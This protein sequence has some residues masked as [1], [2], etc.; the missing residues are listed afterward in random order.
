MKKY[1]NR[2]AIGQSLLSV[3]VLAIFILLAIGSIGEIFGLRI[4]ETEV[5]R[6]GNGDYQE[7]MFTVD[8]KRITTGS[9]DKYG[10]WTGDVKIEWTGGR[11]GYT[12]ECNMI[13]GKRWGWSTRTYNISTMNGP[14][15]E[16]DWYV[17]NRRMPKLKSA[18]LSPES[19]SAFELLCDKYPWFLG[20]L[21]MCGFDSIYIETYMDTVVTLV[22]GHERIF[23]ELFNATVF[24]NYYGDALDSLEETPY[25]SIIS[26]NSDLS[27]LKGFEE[28]KNSELRLAIIDRY[29]LNENSTYNIIKTT[30]SNYLLAM[31]DSG[32]VSQDF[33]VFCQTMD[34]CMNSYGT[35]DTEDDF[36]TDSVD[37]RMYRAINN[38]INVEK[39]VSLLSG[40]S[41]K[42]LSIGHKRLD[43]AELTKA[44]RSLVKPETTKSAPNEVGL[45]VLNDMFLRYYVDGDMMRR[46]FK[47]ACYLK[48]NNELGIPLEIEIPSVATGFENNN[49]ATSVNL[50][51]YILDDGGSE[52]TSKGIAWATCYNPTIH[53]QIL[54]SGQGNSDFIV[55]L[56][57]L[58]E[59]TTYHARTFATNSKGTAYGNCISF[60]ANNAVAENTFRQ[61]DMDY[62]IYPNPT[63]ATVTFSFLLE[64]SEN[65]TLNIFDLSGK[66]VAQKKTGRLL[67]GR[68]Q[69]AMDLSGLPDG[70]YTSLLIVG[71]R[72]VSNQLAIAHK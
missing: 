40:L 46:I 31:N 41:L 48:L 2:T 70:L 15:R 57:G 18:G 34:S 58:K 14:Y 33:E 17:D 51:G 49:S 52:I 69:I 29:L 71:N 21:N 44:F 25:D 36:F 3:I 47:E 19:T 56:N 63:T 28:M 37:V 22:T 53:E 20:S 9:L 10:N 39:S 60:I 54:A 68:N 72:K 24:N 23:G 59:G 8:Q 12:E 30:Y 6:L 67:I 32:V 13:D 11:Y 4:P 5:V 38:I 27:A 66:L 26:L 65:L 7:T 50:G 43:Q 1:L 35:L 61:F 16:V 64:S 42:S 62:K 55:T 45:I